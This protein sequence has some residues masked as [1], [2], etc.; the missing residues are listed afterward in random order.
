VLPTTPSCARRNARVLFASL[1]LFALATP[2]VALPPDNERPAA[3]PV[4]LPHALRDDA[5]VVLSAN[6]DGSLAD[7]HGDLF[8]AGGQL[9]IGNNFQYAPPVEQAA[10]DAPRNEL[11]F[12][13][14]PALGLTVSR[15]VSVDPRGG[16]WRFVEMLENAGAAPVRTQVRLRF[17]LSGVIQNVEQ[18]NHE[19]R[20]DATLGL[21]LF[22]GDDGI[23]LLG[24]GRS[25]RT[26]VLPQYTT[27]VESDA[28][29]VLYEIEVAPRKSVALVHVLAVRPGVNEAANFLR[30]AKDAEVLRGLP[31]DVLRSLGNFS[32][33]DRLVGDAE[34]LRGDLFD[35]V[36][37][38]GGDVYKGTLR[39]ETYEL[40][41]PYGDVSLPA[42]RVLA[43]VTLGQFRPTQL[44]VTSDGEV[45]A[46]TLKGESVRLELS[47][48][49]VTAVPLSNVRRFGYRRR[50]DEPDELRL[51][52]GK[53]LAPLRAGDRIAVEPLRSPIP[54][55]T[56]YGVLRL[57]PRAVASVAF[58][59]Q[60]H[61]VHQVR[62]V[63]GSRFA[64]V[65]AQDRFE[66]TPSG[67]A[68]ARATASPRRP[69]AVAAASLSRLQFAPGVDDVPRDTARL[70]IAN[71]DLLVGSLA[72]RLVIDTAFD[73]IEVDAEGLQGLRQGGAES[74]A[75]DGDGSGET[76]LTLWDGTTLS[77]R[78]R[79]DAVRCKLRC[80]VEVDV[81]VG[82]VRRY[83]HPQPR[84]SPQA[85]ER[86]KAVVGELNAD[87]WKTR[88]RAAAQ[89]SSMGAASAAV[90]KELREGQPPEVRQRIDQILA[91]FDPARGGEAPKS[92][93]N[94]GAE[95]QP[96]EAPDRG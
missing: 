2:L 72:G 43:M 75:A 8:D 15:R 90:L 59:S 60:E 89:L 73:A 69:I 34:V 42:G 45:F 82:M 30:S 21:A 41:T 33:A 4:P 37:V 80:G 7:G 6:T 61:A 24:A 26:T 53:P 62:L 74:G 27:Q 9:F 85:V 56:C 11:S 19:K 1:T 88:D 28:V 79:G 51:P 67:T 70:E 12:P 91:A 39:E 5:G 25:G 14:L 92:P 23:A 94:R 55:A 44:L 65:V 47:S 20:P 66:L 18:V 22:D 50:P 95:D 36:E 83:T 87:D 64:G 54:V 32:T 35:V 76:Q 57:D 3:R 46:G 29:E 63:D 71:G 86:I 78:V 48:G 93:V 81:P 31:P 58:Q 84:P 38:R 52:A 77:G 96:I 49:Q 40:R 68:A 17:D 16:W 10:F 13:P